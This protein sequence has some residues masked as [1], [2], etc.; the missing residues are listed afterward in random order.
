[1]D[2]LG[3]EAIVDVTNTFSY[4]VEGTRGANGMVPG[5][6]EFIT[7]HKFSNVARTQAASHIQEES[8]TNLWSR[9]CSGHYVGL[10]L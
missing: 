10:E 3:A 2:L 8:M 7:A 9:L 6:S 5:F 4:Q 1:M